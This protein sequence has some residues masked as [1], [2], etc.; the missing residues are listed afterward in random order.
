M[1]K[2]RTKG[3]RTGKAGWFPIALELCKAALSGAIR[4]VVSHLLG[5]P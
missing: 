5:H 1:S 3:K 2:V 4:A